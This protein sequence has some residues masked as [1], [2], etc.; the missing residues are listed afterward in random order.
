MITSKSE[1]ESEERQI[2]IPRYLK[3]FQF[4]ANGK[5]NILAMEART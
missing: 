1:E 5:P 2:G 4:V 3:Y